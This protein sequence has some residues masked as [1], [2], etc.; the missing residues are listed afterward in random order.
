VNDPVAE[1]NGLRWSYRHLFARRFFLVEALEKERERERIFILCDDRGLLVEK[2]DR[3]DCYEMPWYVMNLA[4]SHEGSSLSLAVMNLSDDTV[5]RNCARARN[6]GLGDLLNFASEIRLRLNQWRA[7]A[8]DKAG[9]V[10]RESLRAIMFPFCI[11]CCFADS[12]RCHPSI[13][14]ASN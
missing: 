5:I 8:R 4:A 11:A 2:L 10:K 3:W 14:F 9:N 6:G 12:V 13:I 1:H 7:K